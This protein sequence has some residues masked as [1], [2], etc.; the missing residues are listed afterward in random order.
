[1]KSKEGSAD[2]A[3]TYHIDGDGDPLDDFG[4]GLGG[5]PQAPIESLTKAVNAEVIKNI[6]K[7][8]RFCKGCHADVTKSMYCQCGDFDLLKEETLSEEELN[9]LEDGVG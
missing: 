2:N 1:M 4:T 9:K 8:R 6:S 3:L 7:E 5:F